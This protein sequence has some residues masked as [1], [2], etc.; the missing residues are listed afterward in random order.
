MA[1]PIGRR[2]RPI[3]DLADPE[4]DETLASW[5][6]DAGGVAARG[7]VHGDFYRRNILDCDGR[8]ALLDWDEARVDAV[9]VELAWAAWEFGHSGPALD[10]ARAGGFLDEYRRAGGPPYNAGMIVPHIR[11]RLRWEVARSRAAAA[12]GEYHDLAY[13]ADEVRAFAML[14]GVTLADQEP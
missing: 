6:A 11:D 13:E 7:P 4:L 12:V 1:R 8:L 9:S 10:P 2:S 14:R 3:D 5:R